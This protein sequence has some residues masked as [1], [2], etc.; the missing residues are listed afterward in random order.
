[1]PKACTWIDKRIIDEIVECSRLS[2]SSERGVRYHLR[3]YAE[4][5]E[6]RCVP[7]E[8]ADENDVLLFYE[9][10]CSFLSS[11]TAVQALN[12]VKRLHR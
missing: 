11:S 2:T 10:V 3:L 12:S 9:H 7:F 6:S 8:T 1:M 4:H 5:L